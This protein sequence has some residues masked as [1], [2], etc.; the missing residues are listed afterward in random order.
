MSGRPEQ[1]LASCYRLFLL[2]CFLSRH[3]PRVLLHKLRSGLEVGK[4]LLHCIVSCS[5]YLA[6]QSHQR[7]HFEIADYSDYSR[8]WPA[9]VLLA[10]FALRRL[11]KLR[12]C[13]IRLGRV[14]NC[15]ALGYRPC[16]FTILH[17]LGF[18]IGYMMAI[19]KLTAER[20]LPRLRRA[21][22]VLREC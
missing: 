3:F 19:C 18:M 12:Q 20:T 21:R 1:R 11:H 22:A 17:S 10:E 4:Q 2:N 14:E 15:V 6:A 13:C 9:N 7:F 16:D 8:S 5:V